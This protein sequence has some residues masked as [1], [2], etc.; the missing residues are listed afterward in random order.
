MAASA[1]PLPT[2]TLS[3]LQLLGHLT[4]HQLKN[5]KE[6]EEKEGLRIL[7]AKA[8]ALSF[9]ITYDFKQ[10]GI[11]GRLVRLFRSCRSEEESDVPVER[12]VNEILQNSRH[13]LREAIFKVL[14]SSNDQVKM[15]VETLCEDLDCAENAEDF[16]ELYWSHHDDKQT[17][18]NMDEVCAEVCFGFVE[19]SNSIARARES[20]DSFTARDRGI[21][22]TLEYQMLD[23]KQVLKQMSSLINPTMAKWTNKS[24]TLPLDDASRMCLS[25]AMVFIR[26][27]SKEI[28]RHT[29]N[30]LDKLLP[31]ISD[32]SFIIRDQSE[33]P[34]QSPRDLCVVHCSNRVVRLLA[35]LI[36]RSIDGGNFKK[37][38]SS[39]DEEEEEKEVEEKQV[40][41]FKS[42]V[43]V[44][45]EYPDSLK[46][47]EDRVVF[48][49]KQRFTVRSLPRSAQ[50]DSSLEE[51]IVRVELDRGIRS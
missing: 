4:R 12:L 19:S 35:L 16:D 45:M 30:L 23:T 3:S 46:L 7:H 27:G 51:I 32:K 29:R 15:M 43:L 26:S 25:I 44:N 20:Y 42:S 2:L 24:P 33:M 34:K 10:H 31:D 21:Q 9:S 49:S 47:D 50:K 11:F 17:M 13:N 41:Q 6:F 48:Q 14:S 5:T 18:H 22:H 28:R 1:I 36:E 8:L 37:N 40:F 39:G 38:T